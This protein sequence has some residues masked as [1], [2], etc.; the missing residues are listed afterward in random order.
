MRLSYHWSPRVNLIGRGGDGRVSVCVRLREGAH[1]LRRACG[2]SMHARTSMLL[3]FSPSIL[4]HLRW[5]HLIDNWRLLFL[6][7]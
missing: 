3:L 6:I 2:P 1:K 5:Y 7:L 4:I